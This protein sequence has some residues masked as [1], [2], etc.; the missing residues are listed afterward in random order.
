[1]K[2]CVKTEIAFERRAPIDCSAVKSEKI[3]LKVEWTVWNSSINSVSKPQ[4]W[5]VVF[6][7][8]S[9]IDE[10]R[11]GKEIVCFSQGRNSAPRM[12]LISK[13]FP[14]CMQKNLLSALSETKNF[15]IG[16]AKGAS[17]LQTRDRPRQAWFLQP[18]RLVSYKKHFS[19]SALWLFV[20]AVAYVGWTFS[21]YKLL[22]FWSWHAAKFVCFRVG[23][24][25]IY[26]K[27]WRY[28]RSS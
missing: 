12:D 11:G 20:P 15:L 14:L 18:T 28:D 5:L 7:C 25:I 27:S 16:L 9:V 13:P 1:M 6:N 26:G 2:Q 8:R 19:L 22:L 3:K 23:L 10:W 24:T 17:A 21:H 4:H